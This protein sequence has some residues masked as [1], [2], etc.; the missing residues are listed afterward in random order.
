MTNQTQKTLIWARNWHFWPF[1]AKM[2]C[3]LVQV[4]LKRSA[5]SRIF[6]PQNGQKMPFFFLT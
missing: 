6:L 4:A 1:R 3:C 2:V 5:K